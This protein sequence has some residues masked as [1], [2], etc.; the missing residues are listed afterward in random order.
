M[1]PMIKNRVENEG[2]VVELLGRCGLKYTAGARSAFVDG[3]I[4]VGKSDYLVY[5]NRMRPWSPTDAPISEDERKEIL[6]NI[7]QTFAANGMAAEVE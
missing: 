3:E 1:T 4:L 5:Q 2:V 7:L 6:A